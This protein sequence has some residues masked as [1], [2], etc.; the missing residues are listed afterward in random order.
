MSLAPEAF[1][2][3]PAPIPSDEEMHPPLRL[4]RHS[5]KHI[6]RAT[7]EFLGKPQ[8]ELNPSPCTGNGSS[9]TAVQNGKCIDTSMG[10]TPA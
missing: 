2:L 1:L 6:A 3:S 5:H 7:A 4:P 8:S 9:M 10:L